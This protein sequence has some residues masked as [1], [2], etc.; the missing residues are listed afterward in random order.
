MFLGSQVKISKYDYLSLKVHIN[1]AFHVGL[2]CLSKNLF[3][4]IQNEKG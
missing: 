3:T 4:V 1:A 2:H